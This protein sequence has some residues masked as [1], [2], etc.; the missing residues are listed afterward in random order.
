MAR[1]AWFLSGKDFSSITLIIF[2]DPRQTIVPQGKSQMLDTPTIAIVITALVF[3]AGI[4]VT[5]EMLGASKRQLVSL[6][7]TTTRRGNSRAADNRSH[8]RVLIMAQLISRFSKDQTA[9]TAIEY[10]LIAVGISVVIL[11]AVQGIGGTLQTTFSNVATL[12]K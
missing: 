12:L 9:A 4:V 1:S 8:P 3:I 5:S 6:V 10:A 2:Q 11:T 7:Y